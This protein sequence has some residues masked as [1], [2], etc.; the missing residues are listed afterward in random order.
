M[1][2]FLL[3][4]L[5]GLS[6]GERIERTGGFLMQMISFVIPCYRS[7][8]TLPGVIQ[9]IKDTMKTLK[10][11]EY[12]IVLVNDSISFIREAVQTKNSISRFQIP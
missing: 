12:E 6:S 5:N 1:D 10:D 9:E 3:I 8:Q 4:D 7:S 2:N 11:Y